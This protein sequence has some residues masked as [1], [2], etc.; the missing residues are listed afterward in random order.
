MATRIDPT[1][2]EFTRGALAALNEAKT[3]ALAN[4]TLAGVLAGPDMAQTLLT[5]SNA[6]LDPLIAKHSSA[7]PCSEA[8]QP[9]E[10]PYVCAVVEKVISITRLAHNSFRVDVIAFDL[11]S[12]ETFPHSR[13]FKTHKNARKF[14]PGTPFTFKRVMDFDDWVPF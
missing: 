13:T 1:Q 4:A 9:D 7:T 10:N 12:D 6:I 8:N 11:Y 5:L 2:S 3:M 14:K